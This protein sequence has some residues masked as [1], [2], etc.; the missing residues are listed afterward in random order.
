[1]YG[2]SGKVIQ[3]NFSGRKGCKFSQGEV[4]SRGPALFPGQA[5]LL[6]SVIYEALVYKRVK[7]TQQNS[8]QPLSR[9]NLERSREV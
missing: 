4:K 7:L 5:G 3:Q 6:G 8:K 2:R 9:E 1:M